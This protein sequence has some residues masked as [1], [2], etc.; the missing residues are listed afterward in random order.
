M[1]KVELTLSSL[2]DTNFNLKKVVKFD[3]EDWEE[4]N[5][6]QRQALIDEEG[7]QFLNNTV[8]WDYRVL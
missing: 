4:M 1:P 3:D 8:G 6:E 2:E 7:Q 5:R